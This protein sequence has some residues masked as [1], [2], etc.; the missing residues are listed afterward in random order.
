MSDAAYFLG[1]GTYN[2]PNPNPNS[3]SR[4]GRPQP[5]TLF[6]QV[7]DS[8]TAS[9]FESNNNDNNN[10][11]AAANVYGNNEVRGATSTDRQPGQTQFRIFG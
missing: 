9:D 6:A 2:A 1:M 8:P 11:S 4:G 3:D 5:E 7:E 10:H